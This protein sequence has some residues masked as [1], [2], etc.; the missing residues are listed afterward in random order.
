[1]PHT[2]DITALPTLDLSQFEGTAQ[3]RYEF[4]EDLRHA[5]AL[6]HSLDQPLDVEIIGTDPV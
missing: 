3:Q 6:G 4:L 1:M 2:L 5:A